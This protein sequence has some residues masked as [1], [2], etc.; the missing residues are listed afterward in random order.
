MRAAEKAST[1]TQRID[2][3]VNRHPAGFLDLQRRFYRGDPDYVPP[4]TASESWQIDPRKNAYFAHA[5][6]EFFV[7]SCNGQPVGR[8]SA[9]RDRL[10]DEF[11][12]DRVGFFGH[13]EATSADVARMLLGT[14]AEWCRRRDATE[15]RGPVDLSTNYR[16][17]LLIDGQPGP[18]AMMMPYNP[19]VYA[20]WLGDFGLVKAK[21]LLALKVTQQTVDL[22]RL[23]RLTTRLQNKSGTV[24]R[25][26]DLRRFDRELEILWDLYHR[27]WERNWGFAP[28]TRPEFTAQAR[29]LKRVAHPA[30]MHIAEVQGRP[31]GFAIGLPDINIPIKACGGRLLPLGWW[32]FMRALRNTHEIRTIT[33]G[34]VPENRKTGIEVHLLHGV[35][36][37]G[38]EAGFHTCDASWI[39]EDNQD[40]LGPL[41][42]LGAVPHR[43]YRIYSKTLD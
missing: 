37:Q 40:M 25:R 18:P 8:I 19:P 4:L 17:G 36:R 38:I 13:F 34:V 27:I 31:V 28:M 21:D 43:R 23:D 1:T 32:K 29:D 35:I 6:A 39:L 9:A 24:L 7:A 26:I 15:L 14:A 42:T 22:E 10:H 20:D 11:H 12:D 41:A 3:H 16:C 5:T 30:L 2:I 33:L